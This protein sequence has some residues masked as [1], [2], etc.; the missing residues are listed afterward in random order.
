M[1][2]SDL[3]NNIMSDIKEKVVCLEVLK[4]YLSDYDKF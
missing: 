1:I 2:N 3:N 4:N